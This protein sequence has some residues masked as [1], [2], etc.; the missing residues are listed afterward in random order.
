[1]VATM[2]TRASSAEHAVL[3]IWISLSQLSFLAC[4]RRVPDLKRNDHRWILKCEN[5]L[6][7]YKYKYKVVLFHMVCSN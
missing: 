2:A 5:K 4:R 3:Q 7:P 1:M 6:L